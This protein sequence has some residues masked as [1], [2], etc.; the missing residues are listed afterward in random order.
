MTVNYVLSDIIVRLN[1]GS[2]CH[3]KFVTVL[4]SRFALAILRVLHGNGLIR[5]YF[6]E[7]DSDESE[8][9]RVFLK[10]SSAVPAFFKITV[11]S[12]PGCRQYCTKKGLKLKFDHN[13]ISGFY[14]MSTV[15]GLISSRDSLLLHGLGGEVLLQVSL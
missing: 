10:Y 13:H 7:N 6:V 12:T 15:K 9:I 5:G 2:K 1:V 4:Y 8:V 3:F 14:I 11:V